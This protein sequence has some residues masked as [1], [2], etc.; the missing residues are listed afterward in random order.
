MTTEAAP[1]RDTD[2]VLRFVDGAMRGRSVAL[3]AGANVIG[4]AADCDILL[5]GAQA[6]GRWLELVAGD[7]AVALQRL[8]E[9]PVRL[10]DGE[11]DGARRGLAAGDRIAL[12]GATFELDRRDAALDTDAV[13]LVAAAAAPAAAPARAASLGRL[14]AVFAAGFAASVG[15]LWWTLGPAM[16]RSPSAGAGEAAQ[17]QRL[18]SDYPEVQLL[19]GADGKLQLEGFVE[20][21]PRLSAL[22]QSLAPL[23]A[24]VSARVQVAE[25]LVERARLFVADPAIAITYGGNGKLLLSGATDSAALQNKIARLAEDL[26]P[27]VKVHDRVHYRPRA[28]EPGRDAQ[29][30]WT[31]W[32]ELL[33][34]RIVSITAGAEGMRHIQLANGQRLYEGALLKSG[35]RLERIT[36][37]EL[38]IAP[39]GTP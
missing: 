18:L 26:H 29:S 25:T 30:L 16:A 9:A 37:D 38:V 39:E 11:V 22:E 12:G 36:T 35:A 20:S 17:L 33:P 3:K 32:Q 24:R 6:Q 10:N 19:H 31:H 27:A 4:A 21:A 1:R 23:G 34:A 28:S 5:P 7:V 13:F 8:G 14:W 2:W 15:L